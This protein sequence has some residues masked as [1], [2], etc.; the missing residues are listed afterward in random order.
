LGRDAV[1]IVGLSSLGFD[2]SDAGDGRCGDRDDN[3]EDRRDRLHQQARHAAR[4]K[5]NTKTIQVGPDVTR[6]S[7]LKVGD[8]VTFTY[9]ESVALSIVKAGATAPMAQ[10]TPT[11]R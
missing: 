3:R 2:G 5:G 1:W 7:A 11:V 6:F 8:M 10:N 9:Q 4:R